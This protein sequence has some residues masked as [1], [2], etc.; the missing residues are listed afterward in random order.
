MRSNCN[1]TKQNTSCNFQRYYRWS[2]GT[3]WSFRVSQSWRRP[4]S[5]TTTGD[6]RPPTPG[7][8]CGKKTS[9]DEDRLLAAWRVLQ[10]VRP[11]NLIIV[12]RK[13]YEQSY[14]TKCSNP[15]S[16]VLTF[17][18]WQ[19]PF[20]NL[21]RRIFLHR[22]ER[23]FTDLELRPRSTPTT[24]VTAPTTY[25][26]PCCTEDHSKLT[27]VTTSHPATA[28]QTAAETVDKPAPV[29]SLGQGN[30]CSSLNPASSCPG[31]G[32]G[33][34][35]RRKQQRYETSRTVRADKKCHQKYNKDHQP[36]KNGKIYKQWDW[37]LL[38]K[39]NKLRTEKC[40]GR[41]R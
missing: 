41:I 23:P 37:V 29:S 32:G 26:C 2:L 15:S 40:Q 39:L 10:S 33:S 27:G 35:H 22:I 12:T 31:N 3:K 16:I 28:Q 24:L 34:T 25:D 1:P 20:L 14:R 17:R 19:R 8:G 13:T 18:F 7:V 30:V 21:T 11:L 38:T 6:D 5:L 9:P 4:R 36:H